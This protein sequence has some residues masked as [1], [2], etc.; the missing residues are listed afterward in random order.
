MNSQINP[1]DSTSQI[2]SQATSKS[3]KRKSQHSSHSG[4]NRTDTLSLTFAR[5]ME[6]AHIAELETEVAVFEKW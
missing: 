3:S 2:G 5:A 1:E 6:A 4:S